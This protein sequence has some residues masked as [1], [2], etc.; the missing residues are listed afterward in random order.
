MIILHGPKLIFIKA[1]KVGGSSLEIA[2]SFFAGP[3]DVITPIDEDWYRRK[4]PG[5]RGAQNYKEMG[6]Y[7]H[8]PPNELRDRFPLFA[9]FETVAVVR[10][11]WDTAV[12]QYFW[13]KKLGLTNSGFG[14][15]VQ[16]NPD[17][18]SQNDG[19]YQL[20]GKFSLGHYLRYESLNQDLTSLERSYP[21]LNGLAALMMKINAKGDV[22]PKSARDVSAVYAEFPQAVDRVAE[23]R[24]SFIDRFQYPAPIIG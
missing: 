19:I 9:E 5:F 24:R 4:T 16:D 2:L 1:G 18:I 21:E 8:I 20:D 7:N 14:E 17:W 13:A 11:P 6:A 15:F 23:L 12:S 3:A 22:R 10:C